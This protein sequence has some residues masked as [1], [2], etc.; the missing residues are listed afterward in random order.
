VAYVREQGVLRSVDGMAPITE[1]AAAIDQ[2]LPEASASP[3]VRQSEG[4]KKKYSPAA[5]EVPAPKA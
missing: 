4:P 5:P 3:P 1:V 2:A